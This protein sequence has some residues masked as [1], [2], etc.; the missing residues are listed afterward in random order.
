LIQFTI[1]EAVK[2]ELEKAKASS[3]I[4]NQNF[5]PKM[6]FLAFNMTSARKTIEE[7]K[8]TAAAWLSRI[9]PFS[10]SLAKIV[11]PSAS[12]SE[13][14][15]AEQLWNFADGA[16]LLIVNKEGVQFRHPLLQDYYCASYIIDNAFREMQRDNV[17]VVRTNLPGF[18]EAW[19]FVPSLEPTFYDKLFSV[20]ENGKLDE[21]FHSIIFDIVAKLED[22]RFLPKLRE[23]LLDKT[24]VGERCS[25]IGTLLNIGNFDDTKA[26]LDILLSK[27]EDEG[28]RVFAAEFL[29]RFGHGIL[30]L[31][32]QS[33]IDAT[34]D[35]SIKHGITI[36]IKHILQANRIEELAKEEGLIVS[37]QESENDELV[38]SFGYDNS[39]EYKNTP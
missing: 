6:S 18:A 35:E 20:L 38:V 3:K 11:E 27:D 1:Q 15:Q 24:K 14:F 39:K 32:L 37:L 25:A 8:N 33:H 29:G 36:A 23:A 22:E 34:L 5:Q 30:G 7:S 10:T 19:R 26:I 2:Q 28:I 12:F 31:L 13:V 16:G 9:R 4:K 21:I 17:F